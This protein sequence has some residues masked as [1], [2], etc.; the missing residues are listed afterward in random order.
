MWKGASSA[1][2]LFELF[3]FELTVAL[4]RCMKIS[5]LLLTGH[6]DAWT[7]FNGVEDRHV[8][9]P[10]AEFADQA[11]VLE[12]SVLTGFWHPRDVGYPLI[13]LD[14]PDAVDAHAATT[15]L[16]DR[17]NLS[18]QLLRFDGKERL[19]VGIDLVV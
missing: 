6:K 2:I 1:E 7:V 16:D 11:E 12:C 3:S 5:G 4:P 17:L 8:G 14:S 10:L 18:F 13:D 9:E 15:V 19:D